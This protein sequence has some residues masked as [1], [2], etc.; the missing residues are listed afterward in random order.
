MIVDVLFDSALDEAAR[1]VE[2]SG[3]GLA[4]CEATL[5]RDLR[6]KIRLH[7]KGPTGHVWP[8]DARSTLK[9]VLAGV[10]PFG[11]EVVYLEVDKA[12]SKDFPLLQAIEK[13]RVPFEPDLAGGA[14]K[15]RWFR[16]ERRFSKDAWLIE[17]GRSQEPWAFS[18][19]VPVLSFYGFKGGVGRTT[20][21]TAFA[22]HAADT[23]DKNVVVV[24]L[25]LEAPGAGSMLLGEG[26]EA[27]LGV[28]DFLL[29]DRIGRE[30]PL[31]IDRF[32][33]VSPFVSGAGSVRVVP[34]GRLD[35]HYLEKLGRV[36]VQGL[37]DGD[38]PIREPLLALLRR[39]REEARADVILLDV[40]AGLHDIGGVSLSGLSH[41][42]L[43]FAAHTPQTWAGL[44]IVLG[45]LGRLR[46]DWV[47]LV[48]ALVPP[49]ARGGEA[50]HADFVGRAFDVCS[51]H[52]YLADEIP[53]P[54]NEDATHSAYRLPFREALMALGDIGVAKAELL[55]D[56]HR[57]FCEGL[58]GDIGLKK[59]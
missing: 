41:L 25:D 15:A 3:I 17:T 6:G 51:E 2:S 30:A 46:A 37:V 38:R 35:R 59:E 18:E 50:L 47:K 1:A 19:G 21:L 22:L 24:D 55:Q 20:A 13:G 34:A 57:I 29:E 12:H 56:E 39:L 36:D 9:T 42:E 40:R 52:Y 49:L 7:V 45:H 31:S 43:I 54:L 5:L 11:T 23:L 26:I 53:D 8:K 27:D 28:V 44:P 48:H 14:A 58:A 16:L 4:G 10:K 32:W 33:K